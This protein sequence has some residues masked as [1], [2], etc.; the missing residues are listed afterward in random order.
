[1]IEMADEERI[2]TI[3]LRDAWRT[4][5]RRRAKRAISIIKEFTVRHMKA[6]KVKIGKAL[7][8]N[9]WKQGIRN[10]PR[11]VKVQMII[12]KKEKGKK[13]EEVDDGKV[14]WVE[15][16][17]VKFERPLTKD[18]RKKKEDK[19]E[20][21]PAEAA[22]EEI[23]EAVTKAAQKAGKKAAEK[24]Q[25]KAK[26]TPAKKKAA[27]KK[28][29]VKKPVAKKPAKKKSVT[30]KTAAKKVVKKKPVKAKK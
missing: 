21:K 26:K 30:K 4:A 8:E 24:K 9:V 23:K 15:L 27:P 13:D 19:G 14:V 1:M 17:D 6:D 20:K 11:K 7:N 18:E 12:E 16:A 2:Y 10:P 25:A 29:T 3:P 28:A 5:L 22:K